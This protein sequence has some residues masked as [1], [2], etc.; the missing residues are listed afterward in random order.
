MAS[1][2][3]V[4]K[5]VDSGSNVLAT[6][7]GS[8]HTIDSGVTFP[9][10]GTGNAISIAI[11]WD[12][13]SGQTAAGAASSGWQDR[14]LNTELDPDGIMSLSSNEFTLGAGTYHIKWRVPGFFVNRHQSAL[15]LSD[16]TIVTN[17][18]GASAYA[19]TASGY[20]NYENNWTNG[21]TIVTPTTSTAY[22]IRHYCGVGQGTNGL[23]NH[24]PH[25]SID[26]IYTT[27]RIT[28]LK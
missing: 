11:L 21:E 1:I 7:S 16:N 2:L 25:S 6:S 28:K 4:D 13:K 8:G 17:G 3:K 14:T 20:E 5:I 12:Q 19:D 10:G 9:A 18:L 24:G 22:K 15:C 27:V 26:S 23:G